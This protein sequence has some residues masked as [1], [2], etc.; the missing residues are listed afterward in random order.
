MDKAKAAGVFAVSSLIIGCISFAIPF[1]GL[2]A[3]IPGIIAIVKIKR[4][5][6]PRPLR[7]KGPAIS[8]IVLGGFTLVL[9]TVLFIV[10]FTGIQR[11]AAEIMYFRRGEYA[12]AITASEKAIASARNNKGHHKFY[13]LIGLSRMRL[14]QNTGAIPYLE[15]S[16]ELE[17]GYYSAYNNLGNAYGRLKQFDKAIEYYQQAAVL[18]EEDGPTYMKVCANLGNAYSKMGEH[19]KA[20]GFLGQAI[21]LQPDDAELYYNLANIYK[22][23]GND[24]SAIKNYEKALELNP[25]H[26]YARN[27]L[28]NVYLRSGNKNKAQQMHEQSY[29]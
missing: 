19:E 26:S 10:Y 18:A 17:P 27:N 7:G 3:V 28:G 25:G 20:I 29:D 9:H 14:G 16:I 6:A 13:N 23:S 4:H 8:G 22:D 21:A 1:M 5:P 24:E 2:L 12:K 15:K 11:N